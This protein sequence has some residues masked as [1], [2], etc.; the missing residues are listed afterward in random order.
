MLRDALEVYV[1]SY[2]QTLAHIGR[3]LS[4]RSF[5]SVYFLTSGPLKGE[6]YIILTTVTF[7]QLQLDL[8]N[9]PLGR[10]QQACNYEGTHFYLKCSHFLFTSTNCSGENAN[11]F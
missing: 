10:M 4:G 3:G 7:I 5:E 1:E 8:C 6:H 2:Q 11:S 9:T